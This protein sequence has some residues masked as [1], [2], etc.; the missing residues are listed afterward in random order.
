MIDRSVRILLGKEL[1][2]LGRSRG[3]LLSATLIPILLLVVVP[4]PQLIAFSKAIDLPEIPGGGPAGLR[5][6]RGSDF[7]VQLLY[8]LLVTICGM[9]V[10]SLAASY[11]IV[12]EREGRTLELLIALPVRLTDILLAKLLSILI[13]GIVVTVPLFAITAT[14]IVVVG[15]A[16]AGEVALLLVPLVTAVV[17]STCLSLLLTL[18]ARDFRTANN[19]NGILFF[20]VLII[21]VAVLGSVGGTARFVVLGVTLLAIGAVAIIAGSRWITF[22]R[23]LE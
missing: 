9:I 18:L 17:C 10:P 8:P 22:E 14:L 2:Q 6:I 7:F 16:P 4:I 3:A 13:L 12:S 5:S 20:P 15:V 1:A 23:Y 11:T 21:T 19:V